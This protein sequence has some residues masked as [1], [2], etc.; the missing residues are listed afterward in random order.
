MPTMKQKHW[1][2]DDI[3]WDR[4]DASKV[5][6]DILRLAKAA[7]MVEQNGLDYGAYL[8]NVFADDAQF[9]AA[10]D[11]WA[12]EEVQHGHAL[13]RWASLADP[14]FD[15][16]GACE[17]FRAGYRIPL[18]ATSSVRG[19][20]AGELMARC[21]VETGTSSYYSALHDAVDEP[22]L[23]AI[24]AK[25]AA[26]ELR[27]YKLFYSHMKRYLSR[28]KLGTWGRLRIGLGRI[29][30]TEDDELAYAYY[31][32]NDGSEAYD[33]KRNTQAHALRAY[34]V[35]RRSHI[36]RAVAMAFKAVGLKPHGL[37]SRGLT[38]LACWFQRRRIARLEQLAA[39]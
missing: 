9:R 16:A 2:L 26:D 17:R 24:C 30:E 27:H 39:A 34:R 22:V 13:G 37:L 21:I 31:V 36:E 12:K 4:F 35:Y 6:P 18:D 7:A 20:R 5:D 19:S 8:H 15:F 10:A 33:R 28:E 1:T 3:P 38:S 29:F 32:A 25:I 14:S 23:K 11:I